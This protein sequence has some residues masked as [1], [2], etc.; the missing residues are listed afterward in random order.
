MD[1]DLLHANPDALWQAILASEGDVSPSGEAPRAG[2]LP[3]AKLPPLFLD[4]DQQRAAE[5]FRGAIRVLAPAGS[6]KTRTLTARIIRLLQR[7]IPAGRILALAFN[8]KAADEMDARL[9]TLGAAGVAARTLHALG[10]EIVRDGLGWEYRK[11]APGELYRLIRETAAAH[12]P[13]LSRMD[14]IT[15][16]ADTISQGKAGLVN[17][18]GMEILLGDEFVPAG[19]IFR[20]V[21]AAQAARR[22]LTFDDMIYFAVRALVQDADL[23]RRWQAKYDF[24]LVDEFQDLNAAQLWL[25][26]LLALPQNNLFAVGDDDQLIYAWRGA[27]VRH[28]LDFPQTYPGAATVVL[29]A[30]YRSG[31]KIVRHARWLIE[32]NPERAAK[33]IQACHDAPPGMLDISLHDSPAR[34]AEAAAEWMTGIQQATGAPWGNFGMLCRTNGETRWLI[35]TLRA[36]GIPHTPPGDTDPESG[37]PPPEVHPDR[38][39]V[40]TIHKA[41]GKEFPWVVYFN[42][43][44]RGGQALTEADERRVVYVG[45]TRAQRGILI[46]ADCDAPSKFLRELAFNPGYAGFS[47]AYLERRLARLQRKQRRRERRGAGAR[48]IALPAAATTTLSPNSGYAQDTLAQELDMLTTELA[49]RL[50]LQWEPKVL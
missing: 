19:G 27:N 44:H 38:V 17:I 41:K 31:E 32:H 1:A 10:Y 34:Q 37:D 16:L 46:T 43:S 47:S 20:D 13:R 25:V 4:P 35:H 7:G 29:A 15:P 50:Q 45:V 2:S 11:G 12:L 33:N 24:L 23:R 5:H 48:R 30:N 28:T 42:L 22:L 26:R 39:T 8:T 14:D 18:T 3:P 21:V 49:F 6:G 36:R 40:L 9:K